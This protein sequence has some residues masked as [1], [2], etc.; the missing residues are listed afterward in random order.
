[1]VLVPLYEYR[2]RTCDDVFEVRRPMSESNAPASCPDGHVE[3]VRLL[4]VFANAGSAG[5]TP[6]PAPRPAGGGCGASCACA[7]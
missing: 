1:M 5:S 4:S 2:C 6:S 3:T 7:H